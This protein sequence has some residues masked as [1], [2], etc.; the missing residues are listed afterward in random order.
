MEY[1]SLSS[2]SMSRM[3][4]R[5]SS[6]PRYCTRDSEQC[7]RL[8][9]CCFTA[10]RMRLL[11]T[12][13]RVLAVAFDRQEWAGVGQLHDDLQCTLDSCLTWR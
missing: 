10:E 5:R 6:S 9:C 1:G 8:H 13:A 11:K 3:T 7:D 4:C 2:V 12:A